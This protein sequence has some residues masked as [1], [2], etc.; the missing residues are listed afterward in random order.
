M[1]GFV[2]SKWCF[3]LS[4]E[5]LIIALHISKE[6]SFK[7]KLV[8]DHLVEAIEASSIPAEDSDNFQSCY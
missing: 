5:D 2:M 6:G 4:K 1:L 8:S 3:A 7:Q